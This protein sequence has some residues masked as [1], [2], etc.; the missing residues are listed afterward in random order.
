MREIAFVGHLDGARDG[1]V[2]GEREGR[3]QLKVL[4]FPT[5]WSLTVPQ[6]NTKM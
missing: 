6:I 2:R 4:K 3:G 5:T 1:F